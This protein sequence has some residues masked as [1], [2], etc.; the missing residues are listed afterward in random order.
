MS[1]LKNLASKSLETLKDFEAALP[2]VANKRPSAQLKIYEE[3]RAAAE[4]NLNEANSLAFTKNF[5]IFVFGLG[6]V[7]SAIIGAS[8]VPALLVPASVVAVAG[9]GAMCLSSVATDRIV[10][11]AHGYEMTRVMER[12]T[13]LG[14]GVIATSLEK[15]LKTPYLKENFLDRFPGLE[16]RFQKAA[17]VSEKAR[18]TE[19]IRQNRL[20]AGR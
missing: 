2:R 10:A 18:V 16:A 1:A 12:A 19:A 7:F 17:Q 14:D 8:L 4:K 5:K 11:K 15:L 9:L 3:F 20:N 6:G 13:A